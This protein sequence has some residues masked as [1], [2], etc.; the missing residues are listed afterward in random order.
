MKKRQKLRSPNAVIVIGASFFLAFLLATT[1]VCQNIF[2]TQFT[3]GPGVKNKIGYVTLDGPDPNFIE[4]SWIEYSRSGNAPI[5]VSIEARKEI[6]GNGQDP[7]LKL[8][9]K[10]LTVTSDSWQVY[11]F[12]IQSG[13]SIKI[14]FINDQ[15]IRGEMDVNVSIRKLIL[16]ESTTESPAQMDTL[17]SEKVTVTWDPNEEADLA[18]YN[19]YYGK[20]SRQYSDIIQVGKV[21]ETKLNIDKGSIYYLA[22]SA[23]DTANN[24]SNMSDEIVFYIF[25]EASDTSGGK[26]AVDTLFTDS[27]TVVWKANIEPDLKGYRIHWGAASGQYSDSLN[28]VGKVEE[29]K[30]N[31]ESEKMYYLAVTAY[32]TAN[33][34]SNFSNEV[35]FYLSDKEKDSQKTCDI[36][37]DGQISKWDW[38]SLNRMMGSRRGE[39]LYKAS[40]DFNNDGVIDQE[41][42]K[43]AETSCM[44]AWFN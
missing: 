16:G 19:I 23:F 15:W 3:L 31:L 11:S 2:S 26:V 24:T 10:E 13:E 44:A 39:P 25:D 17:Y 27:V 28:I 8:N 36:D 42:K 33:N 32:D 20:K 34:R 37:G 1:G 35:I 9:D 6:T 40:A 5:Q 12:G 41:D 18:G 38:F 43:L 30:L 21:A 4:L 29:K 22:I 14:F 7:V